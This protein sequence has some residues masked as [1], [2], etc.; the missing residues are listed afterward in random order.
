MSNKKPPVNGR[1]QNSLRLLEEALVD[2]LKGAF[3]DSRIDP[4]GPCE[5]PVGDIHEDVGEQ[6]AEQTERPKDNP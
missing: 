1:L 5:E 6:I 4:L 2:A 3:R